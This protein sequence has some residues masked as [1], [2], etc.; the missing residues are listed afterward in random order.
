[1]PPVGWSQ[2][3]EDTEGSDSCCT[4]ESSV[5]ELQQLVTALRGKVRAEREQAEWEARC[6]GRELQGL[7]RQ[8]DEAATAAAEHAAAADA[9][10]AECAELEQS[11]HRLREER[12]RDCAELRPLHARLA[13]LESALE[14]ARVSH[15]NQRAE[16]ES[17]A[18]LRRQAEEREADA[19][20]LQAEAESAA[21]AE[22]AAL[23]R[24]QRGQLEVAAA[25]A[26][27]RQLESTLRRGAVLAAARP[28]PRV[29]A[30]AAA[31]AAPV[32]AAS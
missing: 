19:Q 11:V 30:A 29:A 20:R 5:A 9:A 1:M 28:W 12:R 15:E 25:E 27:E 21:Q 24:A 23:E 8:L 16:V 10:Q 26:R 6:A 22:A 2:Q 7:R 31:A 3:D 14:K 13:Q 18:L 4:E 17:A 32:C